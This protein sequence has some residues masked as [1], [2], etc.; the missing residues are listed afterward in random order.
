VSLERELPGKSS[1][2]IRYIGNRGHRLYTQLELN[3]ANIF[4]NGVLDGFKVTQSGGNAPLFDQMFS[5]LNLGSGIINGTSVTASASLR[6]NST[7]QPFFANNNPGGF[8]NFLNTTTNFTGVAGG[9]I[10]RADLPENLIVV[11]PQYSSAGYAC[12]CVYSS[13]D[14]LQVEY[15]K[16]LSGGLNLLSSYVF[17]KNLGTGDGNIRT[18]RNMDLDKRR[19]NSDRTHVLKISGTYDLPVGP[20]KRFVQQKVLGNVVGGWQLGAIFTADSGTPL[21]ITASSTSF[22]SNTQTA[23]A[24]GLLS[25]NMGEVTKLANGQVVYL[26]DLHQITDP[27]AANVTSQ[28]SLNTKTTMLAFANAQNQPVFVNPAPGTMG[29]MASNFLTGPGHW[30]LDMNLLKRMAVTERY[31]VEFRLD[32][33]NAPNNVQWSNPTGEI[34][35]Q[36]FGRITSVL[37]N[38]SRV[39]IANLRV[40]F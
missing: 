17:S 19:L 29:N 33:L 16:R 6:A 26:P 1:V 4:E 13:Y 24:V 12:N 30:N 35:N 36:N 7:T 39:V 32:A 38:S 11:N 31:Q 40:N 28:Q 25:K 5:G 3:E 10:R 23:T 18:L 21:N 8:A 34:N 9:L 15:N 2:A 37:A 22:N 27:S 20:G 14:S